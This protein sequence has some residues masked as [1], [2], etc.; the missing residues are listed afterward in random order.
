MDLGGKIMSEIEVGFK[1]NASIEGAEEILLNKGFVN[2]YKT[3]KTK[4]VYFGVK[5]INLDGKDETGI[6]N[7]LIR[8]RNFETFENLQLLD[9]SIPE[10]KIRV[11][12]VTAFDYVT[13]IL[14]SGF[15]VLFETEKSD[16]I[17]QKG[18]CYH[19]LQDIKGIGLVDYVYNREIFDLGLSEEEMFQILKKQMCDLGFT[20]EYDLGIDKLRTLYERS[21]GNNG[22]MFSMNQVGLYN[23]QAKE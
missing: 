20:L 22:L 15:V 19:Q 1:I 7:S 8:L 3:A 16:W 17:Y 12:F 5:G 13:R 21:K 14:N 6:K 2:T 10:G 4:D 18:D 23:Y 11:D 9:S